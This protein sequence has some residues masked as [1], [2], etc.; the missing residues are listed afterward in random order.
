MSSCVGNIIFENAHILYNVNEN[1]S[2]WCRMFV[3][4][5]LHIRSGGTCGFLPFLPTTN[6][7]SYSQLFPSPHLNITNSYPPPLSKKKHAVH[8]PLCFYSP[9]ILLPLPLVSDDT[10]RPN[11][12]R[13]DDHKP[14]PEDPGLRR[15][16][17]I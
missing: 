5:S 2:E 3:G 7:T 14:R 9:P 13:D 10:T 8:P 6:Y 12:W 15:L 4:F 16:N 17:Q 1:T 11:V